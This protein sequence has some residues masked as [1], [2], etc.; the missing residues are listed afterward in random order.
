[1]EIEM[2]SD[3]AKAIV[4]E[5]QSLYKLSF[6]R[7]VDFS[8]RYDVSMDQASPSTEDTAAAALSHR[9]FGNY[10]FGRVLRDVVHAHTDRPFTT[11]LNPSCPDALANLESLL[12]HFV[13]DESNRSE[14]AA[15]VLA[16][17]TDG[18]SRS[19]PTSTIQPVDLFAAVSGM[20]GV[21]IAARDVNGVTRK[22]K[23][24]SSEDVFECLIITEG[25]NGWYGQSD[26]ELLH[27]LD[28]LLGSLRLVK[29]LIELSIPWS[30]S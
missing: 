22:Y 13:I 25:D 27:L 4:A 6:E 28:D 24:Y 16:V 7:L 23:G 17:I 14:T 18:I 29:L 11:V 19:S 1:M 15:A 21:E 10:H 20:F 2:D 9:L 8:G 26:G 12:Q 5:Q 30:I 3:E